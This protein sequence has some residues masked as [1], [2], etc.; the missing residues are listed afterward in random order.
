MKHLFNYVLTGTL[1]LAT[2]GCQRQPLDPTGTVGVS[3]GQEVTTQFILNVS[4]APTTKMSADAVQ[5]NNNFRGIEHAVLFTYATGQT[6]KPHVLST[7]ATADKTFDFGTLISAGGLDPNSN[8]NGADAEA[9]T[10]GSKRI[11]SLSIPVHTDAVLFYGKAPKA[12]TGHEADDAYGA[13]QTVNLGTQ[14]KDT[15]FAAVKILSETSTVNAYDA[16]ARLMIWILNNIK[17]RSLSADTESYAERGWTLPAVTWAQ[18]GHRYEYDNYKNDLTRPCRYTVDQ[19]L[20]H[21]VEGLEE[22]LGKCYYL[23][24]YILPVGDGRPHGE[25]RG[26]SSFAVK[27]MIIDM[28]KVITAASEAEPTNAKEAN[29]KRMAQAI[30]NRAKTFFNTDNGKYKEISDIKTQL[31]DTEHL[32]DNTTWNS[33]FK[34]AKDL[35]GYPYEDFGIPEGAAQLGFVVE[36]QSYPTSGY[37]N[38]P[39]TPAPKDEFYYYHPNKPLVNYNMTEFEPRKYLLPAELY[40]YVNSPLRTTSNDVTVAS[41][42]DGVNKWNADASWT[43]WDFPG[44]VSS[45]TRGVAVAH[46][47]N[48]GVAL[49]KSSVKIA[50]G[51]TAFQDNR[52]ALTNHAEANKTIPVSSAQLSLKG[53]LI[54]GVNPRMNW[55]FTRYFTSSTTGNHEPGL[56]DLSKFDGVIYDHTLPSN[57]VPT[58]AESPNYTLVYDNFNSTVLTDKTLQESQN[59]VYVAL[60]FVNNG[61]AF[62]GRD[63]LIH[64][65]ATF[66]LVAKLD[67]PTNDQATSLAWPTDH[68]IA[69]LYRVDNPSETLPEGKAAG[70]SKE[71]ARIFIQDFMTTVTFS[72]GANSLQHAYYSTPDLRASQMSL[73]LDVDLQWTPGLTYNDVAL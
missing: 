27:S 8:L 20:D 62:Y 24:T 16:T 67:K 2:M 46:S 37:I 43:G 11:L 34:D 40:Y 55:Q 33:N 19:C 53:I 41:Y 13:T 6:G 4:S 14:A 49:L 56:G 42:P 39:S 26:G 21:K 17:D 69:P 7:T 51:V 25:Y 15:K 36:G 71:I 28:Y 9:T 57:A 23:F 22:V 45:S 54:G 38:P 64:N 48:Y 3:D 65:G 31:I 70:D 1:L 61:E 10:P 50:T 72:L 60:E 73:G 35:N 59:D 52:Y 29:A 18:Y 47:I 44:K 58:P 5:Q 12:N 63:N 68:H 66:Y 32:F 30:L